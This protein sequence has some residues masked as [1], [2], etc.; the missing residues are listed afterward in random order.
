VLDK[1]RKLGAWAG[2]AFNPPTPLSAIEAS[3]P[4][5]D[6]VLVMSVKPGF[7]GQK[8]D[9][10]A[11]PKLRVLRARDNCDALLEVDGGIDVET[12]GPCAAAGAELMV[13][14]SAI[15]RDD[16]YTTAIRALRSAATTGSAKPQV[17]S[18]VK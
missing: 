2:L 17:K 7:G 9:E 1:I 13:T 10:A 11:L 15:F 4:H 14:G 8:F 5:C 18:G 16:D 12:I 6:L 3:L